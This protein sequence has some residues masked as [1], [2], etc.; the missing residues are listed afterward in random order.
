MGVVGLIGGG[1]GFSWCE[2]SGN[3]ESFEVGKVPPLLR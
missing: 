1:D 3:P 2:L